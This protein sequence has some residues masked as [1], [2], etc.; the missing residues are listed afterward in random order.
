MVSDVAQL[1]ASFGRPGA[2]AFAQHE[3][4]GVVAHLVSAGSSATVA[5]HGAHVLSFQPK[6]GREVLWMSPQAVI[7]PGEGIRG[8]I[9]VCWPWFAAHATDPGK[10]DHGFVRKSVWTVVKTGSE[11]GAAQIELEFP[12][13]TKHAALWPAQAH[14]GVTITLTDTLRVDLVTR[15]TGASQFELTEALHTYFAVGN[16]ADIAVLG[17]Q[18]RSYQDKL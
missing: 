17:L 4:G 7:A 10:P 8:G 15:N 1:N 14:V 5:L 12:F 18:D 13:E 3:L 2:V 11:A 9:P 16:V 6:G